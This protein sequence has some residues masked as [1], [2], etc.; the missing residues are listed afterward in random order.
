MK[1]VTLVAIAFF[2]VVNSYSQEI[3]KILPI[4]SFV[5]EDNESFQLYTT[6]PI[7][8]T[9]SI[10]DTLI[11]YGSVIM[12]SNTWSVINSKV[13]LLNPEVPFTSNLD[14]LF[15]V[16]GDL[17][18]KL[19]DENSS[20]LIEPDGLEVQ[21]TLMQNQKQLIYS[22]FVNET[23]KPVYAAEYLELPSTNSSRYFITLGYDYQFRDFIKI[24]DRYIIT[25]SILKD[26]GCFGIVAAKI[27]KE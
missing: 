19:I 26:P 21:L 22:V 12:P 9:T 17:A 23:V 11:N 6:V 2:S 5:T 1:L 27:N 3:V 20:F 4:D 24:T 8:S 25:I 15:G 18:R 14:S 7:R 10:S 16:Y 13:L